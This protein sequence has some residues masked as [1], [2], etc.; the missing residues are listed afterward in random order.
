MKRVDL[1][2]ALRM[3]FMIQHRCTGTPVEFA[4][5]LE[6]S[7]SV[8]FEYLAYF[9]YELGINILYDKYQETYYY[10]G[11]NLYAALGFSTSAPTPHAPLP[12]CPVQ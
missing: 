9:R 1:K 6:V 7:R 8:L 12:K 10:D 5:K 4:H 11:T 3:N 2:K